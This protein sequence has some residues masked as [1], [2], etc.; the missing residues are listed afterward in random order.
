MSRQPL[1]VEESILR[2]VE[3]LACHLAERSQGRLTSYHLMPYLPLS[4][5]LIRTCLDNMMDGESV[6]SP[7]GE[8]KVVYQFPAYRDLQPQAGML[9][10]ESC[11]ACGLQLPARA[12]SVLC[13]P[14]AETLHRDGERVA[15]THGWAA[16]ALLEH[17][18]LYAAAPYAGKPV[19]V[20][21]LARRAH[22]RLH[23]TRHALK[24]LSLEGYIHQEADPQ[25][26]AL[27]YAFPPLDYPRTL[28]EANARVLQA[29]AGGR[30]RG[31]WGK[32]QRW[33]Y[34]L[35]LV[36]LL[37]GTAWWYV[38]SPAQPP[39][40]LPTSA[41]LPEQTRTAPQPPAASPPTRPSPLYGKAYHAEAMKHATPVQVSIRR[42]GFTPVEMKV[43]ASWKTL[44]PLSPTT[45]AGIRQEPVYRGGSQR[46]GTLWLGTTENNRY[47]FVFDL[48]PGAHP[49]VYFD[50]NQN[51]D[52]SDD[53]S[54]L[55][56]QGSGIFATTIALP[57][58]RLVKEVSF[59]GAYALW[60]FTND[61]LWQR[62]AVAH[63]SRTQLKGTVHLAG[64][65]Y[66][67][68]IADTGDN[69]ANLTNDG[70][71]IDLNG[72]G[73]ID[74]QQEYF[75]PDQVAHIHGQDYVFVITW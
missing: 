70:L 41:V 20:T 55:T 16:Q 73:A 60:F 75:P 29:W 57:F 8:E 5:E 62:S 30:A 40:P 56:N 26:G 49:L 2:L 3:H 15:R 68:Y 34:A 11:V 24:R 48:V 17:A 65:A 33:L 7:A 63:Y 74:R 23:A 43:A 72:D 37:A 21:T 51:G 71:S 67:A 9:S 61:S 54:L 58:R 64:K 18:L 44:T 1:A 59:P 19:S 52:L 38:Q 35:G 45:P 27:V 4:L 47:D 69:D 50:A 66:V 14:C 12:F 32:G 31:L 36:V 10:L 46:Y 6:V 39:R 13:M 42:D 53:G 25:T 22:S 28:Y